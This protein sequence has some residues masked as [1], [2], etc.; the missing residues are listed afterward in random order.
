MFL[1]FLRMPGFAGWDEGS[2]NTLR[3]SDSE[4]L[5]DLTA[6]SFEQVNLSL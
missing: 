4:G 3:H 6:E 1:L 2:L 5:T